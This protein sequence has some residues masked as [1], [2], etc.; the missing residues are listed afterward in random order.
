ML[1]AKG[2]VI[3]GDCAYMLHITN[4]CHL[5]IYTQ[6]LCQQV[7]ARSQYR[8]PVIRWAQTTQLLATSLS[9]LMAAAAVAG[10][11]RG[12]SAGATA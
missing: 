8:T 5:Q 11:A 6:R 12:S 2:Y 3:R 7:S 10:A 1:P 4:H 9:L